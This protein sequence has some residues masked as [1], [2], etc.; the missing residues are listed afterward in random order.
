[1]SKNLPI[2]PLIEHYGGKIPRNIGGWQKIRCP[3]H[4]DTHASAGVSVDEGLFVCHGCGIKGNAIN[5][6]MAVEGKKFREAVKIA[7]GITG[8]S[9][10]ALQQKSSLGRRVSQSSGDRLSRGSKDTIRSRR[11]AVA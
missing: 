6:I 5:I 11:G 1:M 9:H 10:K 7:E 3:F 4:K 8:E 2:K